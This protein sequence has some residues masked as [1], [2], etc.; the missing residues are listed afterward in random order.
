MNHVSSYQFARFDNQ[1]QVVNR[2]A[3]RFEIEESFK[4]MKWLNRLEWQQ[5]KNR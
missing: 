4:D 2:Y 1:S 5:I 3:E